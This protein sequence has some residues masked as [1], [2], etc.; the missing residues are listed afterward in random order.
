MKPVLRERL[1]IKT[2]RPPKPSSSAVTR[3]MQGNK[4]SGTKPELVLRR[5]LRSARIKGL[6]FN[7]KGLPGRPDVALPGQMLAL[8]L[9]GCYWHR[10]PYCALPMPKGNR[11]YWTKKFAANKLRDKKKRRRLWGLGYRI[12]TIWEC[13]LKASEPKVIRR[14]NA[15]LSQG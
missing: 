5:A 9:N 12:L 7:V 13:Q 14:I 15:K 4:A 10:C 6:R 3:S 8:F 11:A 2:P 1:K